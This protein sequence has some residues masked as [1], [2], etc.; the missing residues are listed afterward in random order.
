[1]RKWIYTPLIFAGLLF[2]L[3]NIISI[4]YI[5]N[6]VDGSLESVSTWFV[7][8]MFSGLLKATLWISFYILLFYI[9]FSIFSIISS[10]F[11]LFLAESLCEKKNFSI[12]AELKV[13]KKI[14]LFFFL[15]KVS[16]KRLFIFSILGAVF[17]VLSFLPV[18]SV[19]SNF[20]IMWIISL[21]SM[22]YVMELK[23]MPLIKR[24]KFSFTFFTFFLGLSSF[25]SLSFLIPGALL[26]AFPF[27]VLASTEY[28]MENL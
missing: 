2:F 20:A 9:I 18:V 10:P 26:I 13:L 28:F 7:Y 21:D 27:I 5:S 19:F 14:K 3:G 25:L 16:L 4:S 6:F 24:L 15:L 1:M 23:A 11:N 17:F 8:P 12:A 22:D